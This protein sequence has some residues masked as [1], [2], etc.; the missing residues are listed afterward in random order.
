MDEQAYEALRL[1]L[2]RQLGSVGSSR[3]ESNVGG[4][5]E[6]RFLQ[7]KIKDLDAQYKAHREEGKI[8][9]KG[10]AMETTVAS[11][12][13]GV[14]LPKTQAQR[15]QRLS[16]QMPEQLGRKETQALLSRAEALGVDP[17]IALAIYALENEYGG[18]ASSGAGAKGT[19]QVT[20]PAYDDVLQAYRNPAEARRLGVPP[21]QQ[22]VA[23]SL[24][25]DFSKATPQQL[26][27]AGLLYL[28]LLEN[29]YKVPR[30]LIG[31]AYH[32]GPKEEY[33]RGELPNTYDRTARIWTADH[34][35]MY[36]GLYNQ[37]QQLAGDIA[38]KP[39]TPTARVG[40]STP[41]Q[42]TTSPQA[43]V[44]DPP[45]S[46]GALA[47]LRGVSG[48]SAPSY[49][50]RQALS[51]RE[52]LVRMAEHYRQAGMG[53]EYQQLRTGIQEADKELYRLQGMQG[54]QELEV[55]NDPRRVAAVWGNASG[56]PITLQPRADGSYDLLVNGEVTREG[57]S[58]NQIA[59][60]A[61]AAFDGAYRQQKSAQSA[62]KADKVY[63]SLLKIQEGNEAEMAKRMREIR[64]EEVKGDQ[65]LALEWAKNNYG[66]DIQATGAGDGTVIIRPPGSP[67]YVYNPNGRDVEID[68]VTTRSGGAMLISDLPMP[69]QIRLNNTR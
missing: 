61:R 36:I 43:V 58:K 55:M 29:K 38:P 10:G 9:P 4:V 30:N 28:H 45:L 13:L 62:R 6:A 23:A 31:A 64:V 49:E 35:A 67:P 69:A 39:E 15:F 5:Q 48:I 1:N 25:L 12:V 8:L 57:L 59:D 16:T 56:L 2:T 66:W 47:R 46:T 54:I 3:P 53:A 14:D 52:E 21:Q 24:P 19:M 65:N 32:A 33:T 17:A 42:T 44:G 41:P 63:D 11:P 50:M 34:N 22:Q 18:T 27:D 26:Q 51:E 37:F 7:Q 60:M 68:G 40:V 20:K